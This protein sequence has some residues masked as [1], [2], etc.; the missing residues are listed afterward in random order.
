MKIKKAKF[1][2]EEEALKF[3][4]T[5]EKRNSLFNKLKASSK[6]ITEPEVK[7]KIIIEN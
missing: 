2:M 4:G 5:D 7:M 3:I 6:E 1:N